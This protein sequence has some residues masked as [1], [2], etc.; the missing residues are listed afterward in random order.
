MGLSEY[1]VPTSALCFF[2]VSRS[3]EFHQF[4]VYDYYDPK[5]FYAKLLDK[6][7]RCREELRRLCANMQ[8]F[9][10]QEEVKVND[11]RVYP[12]VVT[13]Y[14]SHRGFMDS[15]YV[16]WVIT[17]RGPL[18]KGLN[19]FENTSERERAEY[20]FEIVWQFPR[21]SRIVGFQISTEAQVV[22]RNTL[23]VTARKG[24]EVGGYEKIEFV[25]Y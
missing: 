8:G 12:K 5:G 6:P 10:D 9:L 17:F 15:P 14:I 2:S 21:R 22:G 4:L 25:L 23:Y 7:K 11:L 19:V 13:A 20:D 16:A 1:V 18:K 24:E 3:G